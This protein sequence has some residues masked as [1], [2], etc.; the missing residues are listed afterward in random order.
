[1]IKVEQLTKKFGEAKVLNS[2][3][4]EV[5]TGEVLG[6]LGPNGA[7]K[8]TTMRILTGFL[9]PTSGSVTIDGKDVVEN[10]L[11]I[12]QKIGYLPENNP[13]YDSM[14]VYEYLEFIAGIKQLPNTADDIKNVVL[15]CHLTEKIASPIGELSKGYR[16]RVGLAAA[17]LGDP[18]ILLLDEPTSGLDPNQALGIRKLIR[19]IGQT[20]TILF[21]TH[22]LAEVQAACDRA[23]IIHNGEIVGQGTVDEL[24]AQASGQSRVRAVIEGPAEEVAQILNA[25]VAVKAL[26]QAAENEYILDVQ[27]GAGSGDGDI[28]RDIFKHCVERGWVLL[29]LQKSDISLE[30]V[31]R[32][33]T[34]S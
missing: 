13:L 20:K 33:L 10:S 11:A 4:F 17:L 15:T 6:F 27:P 24:V 22:I 18:E 21:S 14:R 2:I 5:K 3:S 29:E 26:E 19:A 28:R 1:M 12:R 32:Q 30:D 23:L 25:H 16:Q 8:T 31:F 9:S 34:S 7:G